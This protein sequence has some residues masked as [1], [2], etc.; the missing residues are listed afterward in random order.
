MARQVHDLELLLPPRIPRGSYDVKAGTALV[1]DNGSYTCRVGWAGEDA[2]RVN[3]RSLV[4]RPRAFSKGDVSREYIVGE[5]DQN[6][7]KGLDFT[8]TGFKSPF[9][10]DVVVDFDKQEAILDYAFDR[11]AVSGPEVAHPI[12]LT[13]TVCNP[14]TTRGNMTELVF[15]AYGAPA[16]VF[17]TDVAFSHVHARKQ[18][19]MGLD[20]L[21]VSS[22]HTTTHV[23][24]MVEGEPVLS[25]AARLNLGGMQMTDFLHKLLQLQQ[26]FA[27]SSLGIKTW[28]AAEEIKFQHMYVAEDYPSKLAEF[29]APRTE[30]GLTMAE[31]DALMDHVRR[32]QLPFTP[33]DKET[34]SKLPT[35]QDLAHRAEVKAANAQRLRE[36]N[37]TRRLQ[38]AEELSSKVDTMEATLE[39]AMNPRGRTKPRTVLAQAGFR[40]LDHLKRE[41]SR[42]QSSLRKALRMDAETPAEEE[43]EAAPRDYPLL[44]VPD[45]EL[46]AEQL[47]EKRRQRLMKNA[48]EARERAKRTKE[49]EQAAEEAKRQEDQACFLADPERYKTDMWERH[50]TLKVKMEQWRA[51]KKAASADPN[52]GESR[53]SNAQR[54]RMRLIAEAVDENTK[55]PAKKRRVLDTFGADDAD[56]NVYK[57]MDRHASDSDAEAEAED[58]AELA[59]TEERLREVDPETAERLI[60]PSGSGSGAQAHVHRAP[61]AE[62]YQLVLSVERIRIPEILFQ[63]SIIGVDQAGISEIISTILAHLPQP[64]LQAVLKGGILL[65]GGSA[66]LPGMMNRIQADLRMC[67]PVGEIWK[68]VG[69]D[70]GP[71]AAWC[72]AAAADPGSLWSSTAVIS[73]AEYEEQ[74]RDRVKSKPSLR[75]RSL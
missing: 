63:P 2:P 15:E 5:C 60:G 46:D 48:E 16:L 26:S 8:R 65:S 29:A 72:G 20:G 54:E 7:L 35:A 75:Y 55:G 40:N 34:S 42:S 47:K 50:T 70:K 32:V 19:Q 57:K 51:Q 64:E 14:P 71:N 45:A 74:G 37:E 56:W 49:E 18:S 27:Y 17:G 12:V 4:S 58:E 68:V 22:G 1:I 31:E 39:L 59:R 13:E 9:D 73:R 33:P 10:M 21:V 69:V 3:F 25:R 28:S 36:M 67:R 24:P 11:L 61:T 53:R 52:G 62:D 43:A 30:K 41:L 44:E 6:S 38:R 23:V 66:Q